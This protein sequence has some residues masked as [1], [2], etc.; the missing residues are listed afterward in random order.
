M[1]GVRHIAYTSSV[2]IHPRNPSF[3]I[4]DHSDTE[5]ALRDCGMET[6]VL[7]MASYADIL[8]KAIAPH[9]IETG[10]W[11]SHS[12]DGCVSFVAKDDCARAAVGVLTDEGHAGA[13]Y[14]ITGPQLLSNR[15]AA[16]PNVIA[17]M[18]ASN[19]KLAPTTVPVP[20]D[21]SSIS[22]WRRPHR[23]TRTPMRIEANTTT[24]GP[25]TMAQRGT[26]SNILPASIGI[27]PLIGLLS[28]VV[29]QVTRSLGHGLIMAQSAANGGELEHSDAA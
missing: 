8:A 21:T 17:K 24:S 23:E 9:A 13:V 15:D 2:G 20:V 4:P 7:R 26:W 10:Q 18:K 5:A 25:A 6:T 28:E 29:V 12:G 27:H 11:V 3:I 14:H 16:A 1:A 22:A 19:A